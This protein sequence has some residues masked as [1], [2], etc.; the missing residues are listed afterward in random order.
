MQTFQYKATINWIDG[1]TEVQYYET[2]EEAEADRK[3]T[4]QLSG[5]LI[6]S[7]RISSN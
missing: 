7:I 1:G 4:L 2:R 5:H 6:R 3:E